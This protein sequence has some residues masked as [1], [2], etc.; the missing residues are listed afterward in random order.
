M[1]V[2]DGLGWH[3]ERYAP[4]ATELARL[5]RQ[6][7]NANR[8]LRSQPNPIAPWDWRDRERAKTSSTTSSSSGLP[9]DPN[10]PDRDCGDFSSHDAAQR[11]HEAA[12]PGDPHR[13]DGNNDSIAFESLQ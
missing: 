9:Y 11:F 5:E 1:L 4:N 13:V 12:G 8:G 2:R 7:R 10:G 3:Y 6:V